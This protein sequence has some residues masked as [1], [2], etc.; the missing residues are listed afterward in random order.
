MVPS[1]SSRTISSLVLAFVFSL[2]LHSAAA[3]QG[4]PV[5]PSKTT[6]PREA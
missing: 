2:A 1:R 6:A 3:A 4:T 5:V